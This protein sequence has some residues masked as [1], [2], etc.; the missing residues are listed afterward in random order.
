VCKCWS[1]PAT[2][3]G[4]GGGGASYKRGKGGGKMGPSAQKKTQNTQG[5]A[6]ATPP[7][8]VTDTKNGTTLNLGAAYTNGGSVP[9]LTSRRER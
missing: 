1:S 4:G 3:I 6:G 7:K 2:L 8:T 9:M 5:L